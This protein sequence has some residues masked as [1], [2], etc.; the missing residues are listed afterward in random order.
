MLGLSGRDGWCYIAVKP[1]LFESSMLWK[2]EYT[3]LGYCIS[4][5]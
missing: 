5:I 2:A 3:T 4:C 1:I